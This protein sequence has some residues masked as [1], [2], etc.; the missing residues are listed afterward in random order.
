[1]AGGGGYAE[2]GK[3]VAAGWSLGVGVS[4]RTG[5]QTLF[6]ESR[7]HAYRN[8]LNGQPY[9]VPFGVVN[10]RHEKY[11]YFWQPLTFGFRF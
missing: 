11:T 1:M 7:V 5:R 8:A 2:M 3:G 10:L 6:L 9:L 4:T